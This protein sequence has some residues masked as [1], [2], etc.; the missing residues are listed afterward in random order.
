MAARTIV[1]VIMAEGLAA[2][3]L[4]RMLT[5]V[6]LLTGVVDGALAI[7]AAGIAVVAVDKK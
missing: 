6:N 5:S 1:L 7:V 3:W 2:F 4:Y